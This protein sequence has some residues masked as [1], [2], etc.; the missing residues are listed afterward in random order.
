MFFVHF[1]I[2]VYAGRFSRA[3]DDWNLTLDEF[4]R[5]SNKQAISS[6]AVDHSEHTD[7][8]AEDKLVGGTFCASPEIL[9]V[10]TSRSHSSFPARYVQDPLAQQR[11]STS[12][13][14]RKASA[15]SYRV[16]KAS[17]LNQS[18]I[19]TK[20][21][22]N[23]ISSKHV[24]RKNAKQRTLR[25]SMKGTTQ[26]Q[27]YFKSKG[28]IRKLKPPKKYADFDLSSPTTR[29]QKVKSLKGARRATL[30][31]EGNHPQFNVAVLALPAQSP[32]I[33][34]EQE[35]VIRPISDNGLRL[36]ISPTQT[37][38][39]RLEMKNTPQERPSFLTEYYKKEWA[40]YV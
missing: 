31:I 39:S 26:R 32:P 5:K 37:S 29:N 30:R 10:P 24:A 18:P 8:H 17:D 14:K 40:G 12:T 33:S 9:S 4:L 3:C 20:S 25:N 27:S 16:R 28:I 11:S 1:F 36:F 19:S 35:L 13:G 34:P 38:K 6:Q 23:V 21:K 22:E 2:W 15:I 7:Q